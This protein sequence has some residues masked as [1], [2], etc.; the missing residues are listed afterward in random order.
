VL[1]GASTGAPSQIKSLITNLST[2]RFTLIIL[3]HMKVDVLPF[4]MKDLQSISKFAIYSSPIYTDF[5]NPSIVVIKKSAKV[6]YDNGRYGIIED[7]STQRY[8]PDIDQFFNSFTPYAKDFDLHIIILS[9]IGDDGISGALA[10][11]NEGAQ[12]IAADAK[13]CAVYGMP[14]VAVER[15]VAHSV[16]SLEEI[17]H[18]LSQL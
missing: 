11:K 5:V 4:Y 9:G 16:M 15:G 14:R 17:A 7:E 2:L 12:I 18:Y 3:Q 1:I 8:T 13:S 6:E 10:L